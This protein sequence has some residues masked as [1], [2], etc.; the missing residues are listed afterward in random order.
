MRTFNPLKICD[1][2]PSDSIS[3]NKGT[4]LNDNK[5]EHVMGKILEMDFVAKEFFLKKSICGQT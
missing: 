5:K 4:F 2:L 1:N 3:L